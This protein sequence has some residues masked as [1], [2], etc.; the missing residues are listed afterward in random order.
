VS[1]EVFNKIITMILFAFFMVMYTISF[2]TGKSVD[3]QMLLTFLVPTLNHIMHQYTQARVTTK[4]IEADTATSVAQ[5]QANGGNRP[6][7]AGPK[8][9]IL[10]E[11]K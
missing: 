1:Q 9:I 4:N 6:A 5:I 3:W 11:P 8:P 2:L 10:Q 7:A